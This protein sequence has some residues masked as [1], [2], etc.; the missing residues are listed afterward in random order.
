MRKTVL[1]CALVAYLIAFNSNRPNYEWEQK[2]VPE[3]TINAVVINRNNGFTLI[4]SKINTDCLFPKISKNLD[5]QIKKQLKDIEQQE[6][7]EQIKQKK[8]Q[9]NRDLKL[10]GNIADGEAGSDWLSNEQ[11]ELVICVIRNRIKSKDFPNTL[12][13]VIYE[14]NPIIQY[15]SAW[16]GS[17]NKTPS[18]RAIKNVKN[19]LEGRYT[20]PEGVVY[21]SER[22]Q[23]KVY[24]QF[25][26]KYTGTTT[27][28]CYGK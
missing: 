6:I 22:I 21:Q 2:N 26:N 3:T 9:D 14:R 15:Q 11:Q 4:E 13:D 10:Y 16:S 20:C 19:V 7:Q 8:I 1:C 12:H 28:F 5:N 25:Y 27:Y 17:L 24:K 18:D 23:G